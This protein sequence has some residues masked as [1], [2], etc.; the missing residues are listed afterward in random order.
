MVVFTVTLFVALVAGWAHRTVFDSHEFSVRAMAMLDSAEVRRELAEQITDQILIQG[1]STLASYRSVLVGVV[2]DII[3]TDAFRSAFRTAVEETHR[4]VM[5]KH[6]DK[7]L[8]Q[9]GASLTDLTGSAEDASP[10]LAQSL[11]NSVDSVL[12]DVT[13]VVDRIDPFRVGRHVDDVATV[14]TVLTSLSAGAAIALARRR[15]RALM[16]LGMA[17]AVAAIGVLA[18]VAAVPNIAADRITE[19]ALVAPV[20]AGVT[21]FMADLG[22]L[23]V[24]VLA[25]GVLIAAAATATAPPHMAN[26]LRHVGPRMAQAITGGLGP[27]LQAMAGGGLVLAGIV[28]FFDSAT[29]IAI[30]LS[31]AGAVLGYVGLIA[32]FNAILGA[33][34]APAE[35]LVHRDLAGVEW[36]PRLVVMCVLAAVLA[37]TVGVLGVTTIVQT[38]DEFKAAGELRCNG[39]THLCDR[40]LDQVVFAGTHNS[41]SSSSD[42]GWLFA[43]QLTGIPAQLHAGVRALLVKSHYGIPTGV[44]VGG[45]ELVVTDESD[46][47]AV[48]RAEEIA[49]LGPE[50]V[51]RADQLRATTEPTASSRDIYLCHVYCELGATKFSVALHDLRR[52]I[53]SHPDDVIMLFIG[54]YVSAAD[55]G[56]GVRAGRAHRPAVDLRHVEAPTHPPRDDR[57]PANPPRAERA[58][59]AAT[60]LVHE[61]LRHLP[62]HTVHVTRHRATQLRSQPRPGGRSLFE[63]NHFITNAK[64]PSAQEAEQVE[65][66]RGPDRPGRPVPAAT[67]EAADDPGRRLRQT[68][69]DLMGVVDRLN[70]R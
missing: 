36:G 31:A 29:A 52:F 47:T 30:G 57:H 1:D 14:A 58:Q 37:I 18:L 26:D 3:E 42:P 55:T 45:S 53:D 69:G 46:E 4:T 13:P 16:W 38:G 12:V 54:D 33:E 56:R 35:G 11:P 41:M 21:R 62:G 7:A 49:E 34:P 67:G 6:A 66:G 51:A 20:R 50:A 68:V 48:N 44:S 22:T 24:A 32:L 10:G 2:S 25:L 5:L 28:V 23:A 17:A 19:P 70:G 60:A 39:S 15:R 59:P 43:E 64:P 8:L 27:R 61:G 63:I 65:L 40:P 9:L